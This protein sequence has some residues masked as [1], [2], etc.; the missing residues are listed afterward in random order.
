MK[1]F[2]MS[3]Q[4]KI[5]EEA[6]KLNPIDDLMFRK[7]AED[8]GFCQ[9][10]LRVILGDD[11]LTVLESIP[12]W[13]GTNLQGRS[14]ILDAKCV[15]GDGSQVDIEIQKA[16]D[17]D[18]QRR[19]RYNGAILTTNVCDPGTKFEN[20]PD[21]TVV[22]I[23]KFDIF[24][25]NLPLY[26]VDRV[27]R[28][29]G[30]TVDNGFEE[31]YVNTKVKDDSEVSEL[32]EVFVTDTAYNSK[33]PKT[34]DGKRR[35]KETERGLDVMCEIME[36]L[37]TEARDEGKAEGKAEGKTEGIAE[38]TLKTLF[39]LVEDGV[40]SIKEAAKRADMTEVIFMEKT[41]QFKA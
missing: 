31:V 20:V 38:G 3:Y 14:V 34:S 16:N 30:K 7:M 39:S 28:E 22:F 13:S 2:R 41:K 6:K 18:H 36:R 29:T 19:V 25:G 23:S 21:V 1:G 32:M 12:Q 24:D 33:F 17:D 15:R 9:E 35:Y 4:V 26:H 8:K 11:E 5:R 10:I 40:L 27:V 37:T